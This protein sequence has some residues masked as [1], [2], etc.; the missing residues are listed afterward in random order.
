M[1]G[2]DPLEE[3]DSVFE[4]YATA[5]GY[6]VREWNSLQSN[7]CDL[8]CIV[9]DPR[10]GEPV[11]PGQIELMIETSKV[12]SAYR[13][14]WHSVPN[15]RGQRNLLLKSAEK[16]QSP[17]IYKEIDWLIRNAN[18]VGAQRDDAVHSP[19]AMQLGTPLEFVAESFGGHPRATN[20]KNKKLLDEFKAY[21]QRAMLLRDYAYALR[22]H[23]LACHHSPDA[24]PPLPRRPSLPDAPGKNR[25]ADQR[26]S[27]PPKSP[28][29]PPRSSRA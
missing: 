8:F 25:Q 19:F 15:D 16:M 13:A 11:A 5:I 23:L 20:L 14:I 9:L 27:S 1:A 6:L 24:P 29:R 22:L 12:G 2:Y 17:D 26:R 28:K 4:P 10:L 21:T 18:A 7:L 3:W